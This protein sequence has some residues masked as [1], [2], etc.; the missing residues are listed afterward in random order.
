MP[1]VSDADLVSIVHRAR[2]V[3]DT[4]KINHDAAKQHLQCANAELEAAEVFSSAPE[5]K[6][7]AIQRAAEQLD[8]VRK[9][10]ATAQDALLHS[11]IICHD[12]ENLAAKAGIDVPHAPDPITPTGSP[13][14][15]ASS[16][17]PIALT[18]IHRAPCSP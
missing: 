9:L 10:H 5:L 2:S 13:P 3:Y 17:Q 16:N 4:A 18:E 14:S 1:H 6:H 8:V 12:A 15:A 11:E 7:A